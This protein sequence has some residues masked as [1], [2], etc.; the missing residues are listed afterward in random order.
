[1]RVTHGDDCVDN[2]NKLFVSLIVYLAARSGVHGSVSRVLSFLNSAT[3][4][5]GISRSCIWLLLIKS[6]LWK[7]MSQLIYYGVYELENVSSRV[8][9]FENTQVNFLVIVCR[10]TIFPRKTWLGLV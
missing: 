8:E 10:R 1:M 2:G 3:G 4:S 7:H 5:S 6:F 9:L